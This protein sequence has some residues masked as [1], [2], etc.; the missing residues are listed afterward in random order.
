MKTPT[1]IRLSL[2][3]Q[4]APTPNAARDAAVHK[5]NPAHPLVVGHHEVGLVPHFLSSPHSTHHL[6]NS[7]LVRLAP[8]RRPRRDSPPPRGLTCRRNRYPSTAPVLNQGGSGVEEDGNIS[9]PQTWNLFRHLIDSTQSKTPQKH[10]ITK[11]MYT[12]EASSQELRQRFA[13]TATPSKL[14][15][16][17]P[18]KP[19]VSFGVWHIDARVDESGTLSA[20]AK[21][22]LEATRQRDRINALLRSCTQVALR[23]PPSTS[24]ARLLN[25]AA[26]WALLCQLGIAPITHPTEALPLPPDLYSHLVIPPIP[27]NM[28]PEHDG[29]CRA[30]H[31]KA[32]HKHY[33]DSSEVAYV[34]VATYL[35][36]SRMVLAVI[37]N[38]VRLLA[39]GSIITDSSETAEEAAIARAL[40]STSAT[41]ILSDSKSVLSICPKA[42][43]PHHGLVYT[44]LA[45][46]PPTSLV[47]RRSTPSPEV[48][49]SRAES[50]PAP[51]LE[52]LL[53]FRDIL[54]YYRDTRRVYTPP[55]P[56]LTL[57]QASH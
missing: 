23:L 37:N 53:T 16:P 2:A 12:S 39:S 22:T 8:V 41:K 51:A 32:P 15:R 48:L 6:R 28:H 10:I 47:R 4:Q 55:A 17:K 20:S 26:G 9:L 1:C 50:D 18:N 45:P 33:G 36:G 3:V 46:H 52:L 57:T 11:L 19:P 25:L 40:I 13:H 7:Y 31:A 27:N 54:T 30:A 21:R 24:T 56:S 38:Q 43:Y 29:K 35:S 5:G 44:L 42:W 49:L 34:D 14:S